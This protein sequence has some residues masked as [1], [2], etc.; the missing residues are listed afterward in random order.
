MECVILH[1]DNLNN[2]NDHSNGRYCP[3]CEKF[4]TKGSVFYHVRTNEHLYNMRFHGMT[5]T[6][7]NANWLHHKKHLVS[8]EV[9]RISNVALLEGDGILF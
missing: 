1:A 4:M 7:T 5:K 2:P 6:I 8:M 9:P 3:V